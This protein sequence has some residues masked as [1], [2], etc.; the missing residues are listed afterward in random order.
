MNL[1]DFAKKHRLKA[2]LIPLALALSPLANADDIDLFAGSGGG[3]ARPNLLIVV[4]NTSNWSAANQGWTDAELGA[5]IKQGQSELRALKD[6]IATVTDNVNIGLMEITDA[7][8]STPDGGYVRYSMKQM[9]SAN[10][11]S[12]GTLMDSIYGSFNNPS[13][14]VGSSA[15]YGEVMFEVFKYFGG[16]TSPANAFSD[17]AGTPQ[18]ASYYG[19]YRY[20]GNP[21]TN[22]DST[23]F[24]DA[25]TKLQYTPASGDPAETCAGKN[26]VI[27]IGNGFPNAD[28]GSA[29]FLTNVGGNTAQIYNEAPTSK[30]RYA[31][32]WARFLYQTDVSAIA[33]R[34]NVTSYTIDVCKDAC[35]AYQERLLK[36][37]AKVGGGAYY[38]AT[39]RAA[40]VNALK[41]ILAEIQ[42]VST[43][44]ASASLPVTV[45]T[46]GTYL[47]QVFI[48]MFRPDANAAPRWMGNIKQYKFK[49][50]AEGADYTLQLVD[51]NSNPAISG[52][53]GFVTPCA[54]SY[55]TPSTTDTYWTYNPSGTCSTVDGAA[56][57]NSPDG[58][59]VEKGGAAYQ[60][61][62]LIGLTTGNG[63]WNSR[64]I[65]TCSD[66]TCS[67]VGDFVTTHAALTTTAMG[68]STT[69][70]RDNLVNWIRGKDYVSSTSGENDANI[71]SYTAD[72]RPSVHGDVVHSRPLAMDFGTAGTPDVKVFYG[73]NDGMLH[74]INADQT[75]SEGTEMWSFVAP[76]HWSSLKRLWEN[77]PLIN[78]PNLPSGITPT[79]TAKNYYFDGSIGFYRSGSTA[80]IYPAMRRGGRAIY[81][82]DVSTPASPTLKWR[83]GCPNQSNDTDCSTGWTAIGQTWSTP[84]SALV[85]GYVDGSSNPK[86]VL[87]M[88]GGHDTCE[89]SEPASCASP[90]GAVIYVIDAD[91]GTLLKELVTTRSVVAEVTLV[92]TD[93]NGKVDLAY[94]VDTGGNIY[95]IN[96]GSAVPASWTITK[97]ASVGCDTPNTACSY[98]RKFMFS[99]EVVL[100]SQY[101]S[102][103]VGS[104]DRE[105]PLPSHNATTVDNAFFMIKDKPSDSAWLD[106]DTDVAS[107]GYCDGVNVI[108]KGS[109][110]EIDPDATTSPSQVLLDAKKGW[111]LSLGSGIHNGEQVVTSAV[112]VGGTAYFSTHTPSS[113]GTCGQNLGIARA[114]AV[115]YLNAD[116]IGGPSRY[117][118]FVGGGLPPSPVAGLVEVDNPSG[119]GT[120]TLPFIIGGKDTSGDATVSPLE[121]KKASVTSFGTSARVYWYIER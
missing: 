39:D 97:I 34:Q 51:K 114:Y 42:S 6:V 36:S 77:S 1:T 104:G 82:F 22:T 71:N 94:A 89:D 49:A 17:T 12:F 37:M 11:T 92:D 67:G 45:N 56:N 119:G 106:H 54:V 2:G 79:P 65:K 16:Y 64:T 52:S 55:W 91:D 116:S 99:P 69:T 47:N 102:V 53:T 100:G 35:D 74:A 21:D 27:F 32:E 98:K 88:G 111:Y 9:T 13:E 68:V 58:E 50:T 57:S 95:R 61:R 96:I 75:D 31:D 84:K 80:W 108:C 15:G 44:F 7:S 40:I 59:I 5:N 28:S 120:I 38:R 86:P 63:K 113:A 3:L 29:T 110:L 78:F 46:Q 105:H 117:D 24:V 25:G 109:L 87:F 107:P 76:E 90:K 93:H 20:A 18:N 103:L 14:T 70:D 30:N 121:A 62:D 19:P 115:S 83:R 33:G 10:R 48:G 26:Y 23:A 43:A 8:G 81:A 85:E 73:G 41:K 101:Y 112:V 60:L 72:T 118:T 4:D 66:S